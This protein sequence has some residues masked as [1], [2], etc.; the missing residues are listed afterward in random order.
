MAK[1]LYLKEGFKVK[2]LL[3]GAGNYNFDWEAKAVRS[4]YEDYKVIMKKSSFK[5]SQIGDDEERDPNG[6]G[7]PFVNP[8]S[9]TN[10]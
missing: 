8:A 4:G 7:K 10:N 9:T 3:G 6:S 1:R 2:E 5:S